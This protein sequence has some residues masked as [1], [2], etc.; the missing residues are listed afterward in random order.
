M[1][2]NKKS[3]TATGKLIS[4]ELTS[5][6]DGEDFKQAV[7]VYVQSELQMDYAEFFQRLMEF[8]QNGYCSISMVEIE[9]G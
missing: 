3:D 6:A 7:K 4:I 8:R 9:G 5:P 2:V 1:Q